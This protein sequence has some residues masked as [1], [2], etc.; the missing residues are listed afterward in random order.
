MFVKLSVKLWVGSAL[1][2]LSACFPRTEPAAPMP[3]VGMANPAA[4]Y[5]E[6]TG[7]RNESRADPD[8]GEFGVCVFPDGSECPDFEYY[9]GRCKPGDYQVAPTPALHPPRYV[10]R[11][12]GFI[13]EADCGYAGWGNKVVFNCASEAGEPFSLI[14]GYGWADEQIQS[15][16]YEADIGEWRDDGAFKL[17]GQ[18]VPQKILMV[19][20]TVRLV[21]YGPNLEAGRLRLSI[22]L[23]APQGGVGQFEATQEMRTKAETILSTFAFLDGSMPEVKVIP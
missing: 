1:L 23:T 11:K 8:G 16:D 12:Y 20:N 5:C 21:A 3:A 22:W 7:N 15:L 13:I 10:D 19:N 4:V 2:I 18:D 17:L 6:E 14:I 9:E